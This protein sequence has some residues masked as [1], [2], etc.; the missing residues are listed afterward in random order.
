[1]KV[2]RIQDDEKTLFVFFFFDRKVHKQAGRLE[3]L[4]LADAQSTGL[5]RFGRCR[6]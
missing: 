5:G 4:Q 1:M 2:D 3:A 6:K